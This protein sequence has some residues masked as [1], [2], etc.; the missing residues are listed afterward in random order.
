MTIDPL[1]ARL[2]KNVKKSPTKEALTFLGS[3][4][5]GGVVENKFTYKDIWDETDTLAEN[6]LE[7][8]MKQGDMYVH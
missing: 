7:S 1:L 4:P 8:G 2:E 5:N 3:G 6:L